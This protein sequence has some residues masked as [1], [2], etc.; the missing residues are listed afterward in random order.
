[1]FILE[2]QRLSEVNAF[3][4]INIDKETSTST[5][6][7]RM[8]NNTAKERWK[9]LSRAMSISSNENTSPLSSP[10]LGL[11][12]D[13]FPTSFSENTSETLADLFSM[14]ATEER[15]QAGKYL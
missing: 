7:N 15:K 14:I 6:T 10:K 9:L 11:R 3:Q 8:S 12:R 13:S 1:M 2:C 4:V 5:Q